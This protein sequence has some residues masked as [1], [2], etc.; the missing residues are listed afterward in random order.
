MKTINAVAKELNV[1]KNTLRYYD[2]IGLVCPIRHSNNYRYYTEENLV[3]LKYIKVMKYGGMSL[4]EIK[5]ILDNRRN[6]CNLESTVTLLSNKKQEL[7]KHVEKINSVIKILDQT[8]ELINIKKNNDDSQIK[9][10]IENVYATI[11]EKDQL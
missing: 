3:E 8:N 11:N 2:E 10:L 4:D 6:K 1:S 7:I 9:A 5:T